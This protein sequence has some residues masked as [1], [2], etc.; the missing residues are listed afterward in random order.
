M[1]NVAQA[2]N[3]VG[4]IVGNSDLPGDTVTHA[5]LWQIGVKPRDLGAFP[6]DVYSVANDINSRGQVVGAS[7]DAS[8]CR[9]WL[10]DNGVMIDLNSLVR[11][12]LYLTW[13]GGINDRGEI[14][15]SAFDPSTGE[16]PAFLAIPSPTA[17][18]AGNSVK[19]MMLPANVRASLQRRL[20]LRHLGDGQTAQQ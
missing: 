18:I 4:Q 3:N 6:G 1:N 13:G 17:Q 14:A 15:G 8:S 19:K 9:A 11:S 5:A 7:C 2:I 16:S 20:R 10:W 12:P